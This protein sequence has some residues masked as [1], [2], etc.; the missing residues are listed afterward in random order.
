[1]STP[2]TPHSS[3][4]NS[5]ASI[6]Q[7]LEA[8]HRPSEIS[9]ATG[10]HETKTGLNGTASSASSQQEITRREMAP[11]VKIQIQESLRE[12]YLPTSV[13]KPSLV[14]KLGK[15]SIFLLICGTILVLAAVGVLWFLWV[16]NSQS[17]LWHEIIIQDWLIKTV[18][19]C[20]EVIKQVVT[21][22]LGIAGAMLAALVLERFQVPLPQV[23]SISMMRAGSGS[24]KLLSLSWKRL[25]GKHFSINEIQLSALILLGAMILGM[26]QATSLVLISDVGL[27]TVPGKSSSMDLNI[28]FTYWN[29]TSGD[30]T[31]AYTPEAPILPRGTTWSKKPPFYPT[32]AEYSEPPSIQ[33]G[34]D[35]T[36]LTLRAFLP[37]TSAQDRQNARTYNGKTT[38][39]DA[40]VTC[41]VPILSDETLFD[42]G[43]ALTFEGAVQPSK[44][45]PRLQDAVINDSH[46]YNNESVWFQCLAPT[47][48]EQ[49]YGLI[50]TTL[51]DQWKI[52]ICQLGDAGSDTYGLASEF[53]SDTLPPPEPKGL[54]FPTLGNYGV[55]Y[56]I[57]N[58]TTGSKEQWAAVVGG[59]EPIR[60][61]E[62]SE[63]GEWLNL[64]YSNPPLIFGVTL[65]FSAFRIADIPVSISSNYNR[66]EPAAYYDQSQSRYT[67]SNIRQQLGQG[68]DPAPLE[69]RGILQLEKRPSW[70]ADPSE[71][72][73][74]GTEPFVRDFANMGGGGQQL[75]LGNVG[76]YSAFL[77]SPQG[78]LSDTAPWLVPDPMHIWL[79]QEIVQT[80]GSVAFA[81]QSM[82]TVLSGMAYYDQILQFD[83]NQPVQVDYFVTANNPRHYRGLLAV[84]IALAIHLV[85][86]IT[87]TVLFATGSRLSMLGNTWQ[88]LSQAV[89]EDTK[90]YI[91]VSSMMLDSKV[92]EKMEEDGV[93]KETMGLAQ[94]DESG[95]YG[96][97]RRTRPQ[98]S[99][100]D[101]EAPD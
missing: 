70:I 67:F 47:Y 17:S 85:L 22:Q 42:N 46:S 99:T 25:R 69:E 20:S 92:E 38:V 76:N 53:V 16:G 31:G 66:T 35:D 68:P 26:I 13:P 40:R 98:A 73:P 75:P 65:C 41:Q 29:L 14:Q 23:A 19:I 81:L 12:E 56:L 88:A 10:N 89:T 50:N 72:P 80:G 55:S 49:S 39:L 93:S 96:V 27:A 91:A 2:T 97:V 24:G 57:L 18:T 52:T 71:L 7:S 44:V 79:F 32:F 48:P 74:P 43:Y 34:V 100:P 77:W 84:S 36:G 59:G 37:F 64:V 62:Y 60:P 21:F 4:N 1:M 3:G 82:I 5:T 45:T 83:N 61:P 94:T 30:N 86:I 63:N 101:I 95:I 58:V 33:D 6:V 51:D 15:I 11:A 90:R 28:G 78:P 9:T 87:V 8:T 54:T